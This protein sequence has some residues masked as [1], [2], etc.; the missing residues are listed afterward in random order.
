MKIISL[1][2]GHDANITALENGNILGVW[3]LE[4]VLNKKHFCGVD[5]RNE[6]AGVLYDHVLPKLGWTENDIDIVV[7]GGKTEWTKTEFSNSV[8][9][10]NNFNKE[11]PW[12]E[13]ALTLRGGKKVRC[14]SV[15]HHVNHMAY[16]YYTSPFSSSMIFSYDGVGDGTS[17][18]FGIGFKNHLKVKC[19]LSQEEDRAKYAVDNNG[20]G[21]LYS[22][23]GR[24]FPFLR[25]PNGQDDLLGAAGKAMGLSS[26]G[27]P[28][29]EWR[30]AVRSVITEWMPRPERLIGLLN[31]NT[32]ELADSMSPTAQDL[33]AT[34]QDEAELYV[35]ETIIA[36]EKSLLWTK[37]M[38]FE[39]LNN[40]C[41]VGG[42]ALN[43]QIN[44]R[45]LKAKIP[46]LTCQHS[47][48]DWKEDEVSIIEKLYVP[49]ACSDCGISIGAALYVW[50]H[51]LNNEFNGVE[52][53]SPYLGDT[54]Y[55]H[56]DNASDFN[57]FMSEKY[58]TLEFSKLKDERELIT[59]AANDLNQGLI[60]AWAQ[61]RAE[62]GPRALGNRSIL[63]HPGL[64]NCKKSKAHGIEYKDWPNGGVVT[65]GTMKDTINAKVKHREFWRPFAPVSTWPKATKYF[66]IGHEQPY[67]LE[68]PLVKEWDLGIADIMI[69]KDNEWH[70]KRNYKIMPTWYDIPAVTH[71]DGTGRV[72]TVTSQTNDLLHKLISRFE[73]F[74]NIPVLLN[75]SL[76][77]RGKPIANDLVDILNLLRDTA[78][79]C[80][81]VGNWK[82]WKK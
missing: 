25:K 22:Y 62:I 40:L 14:F 15:L 54:L 68:A 79:D 4:R 16:A 8:P 26:Y 49:P 56:P 82:F 5:E 1:M 77:D 52:W 57:K 27:K 46:N 13:G 59:H 60:L 34:I 42:C 69:N 36:F 21:L 72:Q 74:S 9:Q 67:M 18:M 20:I 47:F 19:I 37:E 45:L 39:G 17:S 66:D 61:G 80:A 43:V 64:P 44:T 28:R 38:P 63:C 31:L 29:D 65:S 30:A 24:L 10:Y 81:Y 76:N 53:H 23:L 48:V 6:I 70:K 33:M 7:F 41:L 58:P 50:H 3:E 73:E 32:A 71:V 51:V 11:E 2:N 35:C 78:L 75:T 12:A 55:N